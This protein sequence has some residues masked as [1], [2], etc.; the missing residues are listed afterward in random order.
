MKILHSADVHLHSD[1]PRRQEALAKMLELGRDERI[2][3]L[4]IAGDLFDDERQ[5]EELRGEVRSLF[6]GLPYPVYAIPGNHDQGAFTAESFFGASFRALTALPFT[7]VDFPGWRLVAVPYREGNFAALAEELGRATAPDKVNILMLHCSWSLPYYNQEDYGDE[8]LRY[9]PVTEDTLTGLGYDYILAGHFHAGYRQRR[10]KCG[11]VF[12]YPGSPVAITAR[13]QGRRAV[14]LV[15]DKGCRPLSLDTWYRQ[16]LEYTLRVTN[17]EAVLQQLARE[18]PLHPQEFCELTVR[19]LGY[20]R[21][22]ETELA[23]RLEKLVGDR[24][25]TRL[26][27]QFRGAGP[28]LADPLYQRI[29]LLLSRDE[30]KSRQLE[31][32][33]LEAFSQALA[34]EK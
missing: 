2:D 20:C 18:L 10:L 5:A 28:I 22:G 25:N 3:L 19:L 32:L 33:L 8:D 4:L 15:E 16:T 14:N 17:S 24:A 31:A 9:L 34:E 21:E 13:E 7:A 11:A 30:E 6:S 27:C 29:H 23:S 12:V 26:D 1:H